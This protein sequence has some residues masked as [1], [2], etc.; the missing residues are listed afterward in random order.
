MTESGTWR[1]RIGSDADKAKRAA[2]TERRR[3]LNDRVI[4]TAKGREARSTRRIE[5][6][7]DAGKLND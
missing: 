6:I 4:E 1:D 7:K 5:S 3:S 2:D